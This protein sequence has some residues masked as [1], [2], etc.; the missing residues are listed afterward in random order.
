MKEFIETTETV[1]LPNSG[2]KEII[3][4]YREPVGLRRALRST[5]VVRRD[6]RVEK[7]VETVEVPGVGPVEFIYQWPVRV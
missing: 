4:I 3:F 5:P 1:Q 6:G 7:Q 2:G